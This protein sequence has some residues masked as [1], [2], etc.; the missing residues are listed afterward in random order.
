[1]NKIKKVIL[2]VSYILFGQ[3]LFATSKKS[4]KLSPLYR[5][6][7]TISNI[8]PHPKGK[9]IAYLDKRNKQL[10]I[11]DLKSKKILNI[12][13]AQV[14]G[15]FFWSP[16][17]FRLFYRYASQNKAGLK[18][19]LAAYDIKLKKSVEI[20]SVEGSTGLLSFDPRLKTTSLLCE[21]TYEDLFPRTS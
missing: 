11:L 5:L 13:K 9:Y 18:T 20:A 19:H 21:D 3:S 1:M 16:Y 12:A 10:K 8:Q 6:P 14:G 2:L 17:G 15:S 4:P 7:S